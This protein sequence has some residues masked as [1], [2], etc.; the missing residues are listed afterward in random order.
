MKIKEKHIK[1]RELGGN[2]MFL[3]SQTLR[4]YQIFDMRF[5]IE[6]EAQQDGHWTKDMEMEQFFESAMPMLIKI[7]EETNAI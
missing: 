7:W 3:D 4:P 5:N 6:Y 1:K 2:S